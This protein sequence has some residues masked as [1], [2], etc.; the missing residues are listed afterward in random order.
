MRYYFYSMATL[1]TNELIHN[2]EQVF[3]LAPESP[4]IRSQSIVVNTPLPPPL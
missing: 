2:P 3:P 1:L 4:F